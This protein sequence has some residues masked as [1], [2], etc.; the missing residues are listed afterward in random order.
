MQ[1][2]VRSQLAHV[3]CS[4]SKTQSGPI[5][6]GKGSARCRDV[7]RGGPSF[8]HSLGNWVLGTVWEMEL[9]E[10]ARNSRTDSFPSR[11]QLW[12]HHVDEGAHTR[13]V[14]GPLPSVPRSKGGRHVCHS[15]T[16]VGGQ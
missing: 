1:R 4:V 3:P 2:S 10:G 16:Y 5:G 6:D 12:G 7:L 14:Q 15:S 11:G 8:G 13:L 9:L